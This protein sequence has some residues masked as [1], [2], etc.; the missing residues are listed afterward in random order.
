MTT[1]IDWLENLY[2]EPPDKPMEIK[3][4]PKCPKCGFRALRLFHCSPVNYFQ[5]GFCD[6][7]IGI[8]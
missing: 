4:L 1:E 8:N 2:D 3:P 5:C 6:H 7:K